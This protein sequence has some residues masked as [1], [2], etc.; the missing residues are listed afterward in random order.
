MVEN[1]SKSASQAPLRYH[2]SERSQKRKL[3]CQ[4]NWGLSSPR[5]QKRLYDLHNV[6]ELILCS[7][8]LTL[9]QC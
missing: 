3:S 1:Q 8:D 2:L 7:P 9:K 5:K 6:D 4:N